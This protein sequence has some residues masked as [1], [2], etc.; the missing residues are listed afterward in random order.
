MRT[1][2]STDYGVYFFRFF[3]EWHHRDQNYGR[4]STSDCSRVIPVS[5]IRP[6]WCYGQNMTTTTVYIIQPFIYKN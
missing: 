5:C 6:V 3:A 4:L 1:D 2:L